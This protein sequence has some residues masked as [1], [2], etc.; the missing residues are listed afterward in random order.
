MFEDLLNQNVR[1]VGAL[2]VAGACALHLG[3]VC[4]WSPPKRSSQGGLTQT[5]NALDVAIEG[6]G[7]FQVQMPMAP[8]PTRATARAQTATFSGYVLGISIPDGSQ[9]ITIARDGVVSVRVANR[10]PCRS[11]NFS[12]PIS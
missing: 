1:Q 6:R 3:T 11:D 2:H 12:S 7:F 5:D 9:S 8:R 4:A 10:I